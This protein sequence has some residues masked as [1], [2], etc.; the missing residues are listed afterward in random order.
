VPVVAHADPAAASR[1]PGHTPIDVICS[2]R[3]A[4]C[5]ARA[6]AVRH[7]IAKALTYLMRR[8]YAACSRRGAS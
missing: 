5:R 1:Q 7:G 2:V 6:G 8:I 3:A 4:G